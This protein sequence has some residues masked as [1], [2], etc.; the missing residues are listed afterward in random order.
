M[1][2]SKRTLSRLV[3][4]IAGCGYALA[5]AEQNFFFADGSNLECCCLF[6]FQRLP[7]VSQPKIKLSQVTRLSPAITGGTKKK[8]VHLAFD[9]YK[10]KRK[11]A[12]R[13]ALRKEQSQRDRVKALTD[14][15]VRLHNA[16]AILTWVGAVTLTDCPTITGSLG[17][18][19]GLSTVSRRR[20]ECRY[21]R[22]AYE[23][24]T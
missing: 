24:T 6:P 17:T 22:R 1:A 23:N 12:S 14:R 5:A 3:C 11:S 20:E 13:S 15:S 19:L 18:V 21:G 10:M 8:S 7:A 2:Q 9:W 4:F 16:S